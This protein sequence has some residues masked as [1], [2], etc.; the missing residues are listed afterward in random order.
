MMADLIRQIAGARSVD[1]DYAQCFTMAAIAPVPLWLASLVAFVPS[2]W[3]NVGMLAVAWVGSV[4]MIRHGVGTLLEVADADAAHH[5]AN[6]VTFAGV[7]A[8]LALMIMMALVVSIILGW[9]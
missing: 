6:R 9:R 1:P 4:A 5:I 2:L 3:F 8:W 7:V